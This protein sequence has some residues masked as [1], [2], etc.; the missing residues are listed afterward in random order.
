M[1]STLNKI[2][3]IQSYYVI[4][5]S[6]LIKVTNSSAKKESLPLSRDFSNTIFGSFYY[7]L[8]GDSYLEVTPTSIYS[9]DAIMNSPQSKAKKEKHNYIITL[10]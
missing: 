4:M 5:I 3:K 2:D 6:H 7:T 1:K 9:I 10:A 8:V